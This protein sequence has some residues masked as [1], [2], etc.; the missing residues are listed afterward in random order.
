MIPPAHMAS[1]PGPILLLCQ[2]SITFSRSPLDLPQARTPAV[3]ELPA[4]HQG[5]W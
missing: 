2:D 4:T 3:L 1:P 5:R